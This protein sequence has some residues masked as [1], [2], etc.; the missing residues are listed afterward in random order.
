MVQF[1]FSLYRLV[2]SEDESH[3]TTSLYFGKAHGCL[4]IKIYSL[5]IE[6][7]H[8]LYL[9]LGFWPHSYKVFFV[10]KDV[11][12]LGEVED[13]SKIGPDL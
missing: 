1:S 4:T 12:D 10:C 3:M 13:M 5:R 7:E 8:W 2:L 11:F 6:L 9:L